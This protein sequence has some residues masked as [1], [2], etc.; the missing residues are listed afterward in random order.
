MRQTPL[1]RSPDCEQA[2]SAGYPVPVQSLFLHLSG[3][4]ALRERTRYCC[5]CGHST[6][7]DRRVLVVEW[8]G[9]HGKSREHLR[10]AVAT[11][12]KFQTLPTIQPHRDFLGREK[13]FEPSLLLQR[14]GKHRSILSSASTQYRHCEQ[15]IPRPDEDL[16][17][18]SSGIPQQFLATKRLLRS[19]LWLCNSQHSSGSYAS[20]RM[21]SEG[22]WATICEHFS[23][24]TNFPP[25][26]PIH[27]RWRFHLSRRSSVP[28]PNNSCR[29]LCSVSP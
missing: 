9:H 10:D 20:S 12:T 24:L 19:A 25:G 6:G 26:E 7:A 21:D 8:K 3:F 1:A 2:H 23:V 18:S 16:R 14:L 5:R 28:Q 29:Y 27:P 11:S 15:P 17:V 13:P 4:Q 22:N